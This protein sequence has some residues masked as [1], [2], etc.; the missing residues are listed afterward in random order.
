MLDGFPRSGFRRLSRFQDA[1]LVAD[2]ARLCGDWP[3]GWASPPEGFD[4]PEAI[5]AARTHLAALRT[6]GARLRVSSKDRRRYLA[7]APEA[8]RF[9]AGDDVQGFE[10]RLCA[11]VAR[12]YARA[13]AVAWCEAA[14]R[15]DDEQLEAFANLADGFLP[16][17]DR[18]RWSTRHA[19]VRRRYVEEGERGR[20]FEY[21]EDAFN[22]LTELAELAR[23]TSSANKAPGRRREVAR[24]FFVHRLAGVYALTTGVEPPMDGGNIGAAFD[25]RG[26]R[27]R[28]P[29]PWHGFVNAALDLTGIR[30]GAT[31]DSILRDAAGDE[32]AVFRIR[33]LADD[34]WSR[35]Q[36][37]WRLEYAKLPG[38][39][40]ESE[41]GCTP[42]APTAREE[43]YEHPGSSYVGRTGEG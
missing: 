36:G 20:W 23:K 32:W 25:D 2:I 15:E 34:E 4:E 1:R 31:T 3:S 42:F 18:F 33:D 35:A 13:D 40:I 29:D 37:L 9:A 28:R 17:L 16:H 41:V 39:D 26:G 30:G 27:K 5:E 7:S 38:A 10:A 21:A 19:L 12:A 8:V 6:I 11:I 43:A 24:K 22:G 14:G